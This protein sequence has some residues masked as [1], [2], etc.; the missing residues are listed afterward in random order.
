MTLDT[1]EGLHKLDLFISNMK[2]TYSKFREVIKRAENMRLFVQ[3]YNANTKEYLNWVTAVGKISTNDGGAEKYIKAH[4]AR[5]I[6][7]FRLRFED[8]C[9]KV[10]EA[11]EQRFFKDDLEKIIKLGEDGVGW[12]D[13]IEK[14]Y[15]AVHSI[16]YMETEDKI[17]RTTLSFYLTFFS[18]LPNTRDLPINIFAKGPCG[19][20]SIEKDCQK[21]RWDVEPKVNPTDPEKWKLECTSHKNLPFWI[22]SNSFEIRSAYYGAVLWNRVTWVWFHPRIRFVIRYH[23]KSKEK[24]FAFYTPKGEMKK[25][26]CILPDFKFDPANGSINMIPTPGAKTENLVQWKAYGPFPVPLLLTLALQN[27]LQVTVGQL[28]QF[29]APTTQVID[30][31]PI[32]YY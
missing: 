24:T 10:E 2:Q 9:K 11:F 18:K 16:K 5:Q 19:I 12:L 29:E 8:A 28:L 1:C 7:Q 13:A 6:D 31:T 26:Q 4:E 27:H 30:S 20:M 25:G 14:Y 22:I 23:W 15:D 21:W 32:L 3:Y 17:K